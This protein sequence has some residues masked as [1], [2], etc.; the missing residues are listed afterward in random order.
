MSCISFGI[1]Y[2]KM[3][4][5]EEVFTEFLSSLAEKKCKK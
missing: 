5:Y 1:G 3:P 2:G 4:Q